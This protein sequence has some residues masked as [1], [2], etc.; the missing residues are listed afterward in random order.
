MSFITGLYLIVNYNFDE[1]VPVVPFFVPLFSDEK[2]GFGT[3][4]TPI[5]REVG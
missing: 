2:Y 3:S 5:N 1:H 4:I